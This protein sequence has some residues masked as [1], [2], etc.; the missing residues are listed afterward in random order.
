MNIG[1]AFDLEGTSVNLEPQRHSAHLSAAASFNI[2]LEYEFAVARLPHFI[3]GPDEKVA[4]EIFELSQATLTLGR[5]EFVREFLARD[6]AAFDQSLSST[7]VKPRDG[8]FEFLDWLEQ[9]RVRVGLGSL[10]S[11]HQAVAILSRAGLTERFVGTAVL[12]EDVINLK[13]APDV[14]LA[15]ARLMDVHP[16]SQIVFEDSPRGVQAAIGAGSHPI[17]MPVVH[18]VAARRALE[19][20]KPLAVFYDWRDPALRRF[21]AELVEVLRQRDGRGDTQVEKRV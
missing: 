21:V 20:A 18:T 16:N 17:G 19:H 9:L 13:P 7:E 12:R 2:A 5:E 11:R 10:T 15:T 6:A 4:E 14:F 1:A 3:G 8:F